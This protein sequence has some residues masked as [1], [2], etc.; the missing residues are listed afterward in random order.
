MQ[1]ETANSIGV[2]IIEPNRTIL[3]GLEKLI[4][5]AGSRLSLTGSASSWQD[6][7]E[8]MKTRAPEVILLSAI[9]GEA[10]VPGGLSQT[11]ERVNARVLVLIPRRDPA[12][13]ERIILDG[14]RGVVDCEG[15]PERIITAIT[16]I[17]EGEVWVNRASVTRLVEC[18]RQ[19][20]VRPVDPEQRKIATLTGRERQLVAT[21]AKHPGATAKTIADLLNISA[22][23]ARNHLNSVYDKLQVANR[24]ELF[25]YV[26]RHRLV[27]L[28][29]ALH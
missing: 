29:E 6:A 8:R 9:H 2:L 13:E 25:D 5:S 16:K 19:R 1:M 14:A 23:T 27:D 24:V 28:A 20:S 21:F 26:H 12:V 3:W 11:L 10:H 7:F 17:Q 4:E 15:P 22:H 18:A